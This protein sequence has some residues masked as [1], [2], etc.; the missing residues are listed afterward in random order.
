MP[1]LR[2]TMGNDEENGRASNPNIDNDC[3]GNSE[4]SDGGSKGPFDPY[5][6][7]TKLS[8]N[9]QWP[10][11]MIE[12]KK[13]QPAAVVPRRE[14]VRSAA[15]LPPIEVPGVIAVPWRRWICW[16]R[17][18]SWAPKADGRYAYVLNS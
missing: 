15:N 13:N 12:R 18:Q 14:T 7:H 2:K 11:E 5:W 3:E 9:V 4:S 16:H 17:G 8:P 1:K 10:V 6:P